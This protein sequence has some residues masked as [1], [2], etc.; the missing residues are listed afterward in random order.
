MVFRHISNIVHYIRG[1]WTRENYLMDKYQAHSNEKLQA[2][3]DNYDDGTNIGEAI[4][5]YADDVYTLGMLHG[6][7]LGR[8]EVLKWVSEQDNQ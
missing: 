8:S 2:L 4:A 6:A 7:R 1:K 5:D 3:V